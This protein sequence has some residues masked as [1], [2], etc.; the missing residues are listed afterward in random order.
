MGDH[1]EALQIDFDP[2][3]LSYEALLARIWAGHDP[4]RS[5]GSV[6]YRAAI[7]THDERQAEI[8]RRT[9][10][11]AAA[12]AGGVLCTA[13]EPLTRFYRAEDYH[14]KYSLRRVRALEEELLARLGS[15]RAMVDSTVAARINALLRGYGDVEAA[16][17]TLDLSPRAEA[18]LRA[19]L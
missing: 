6:Q 11:A 19:R 7:W 16:L 4:T 1:T 2:R 9:G 13:I 3:A 10:E 17:P 18:A 12:A 8:A 5:R 15:D 14:Q